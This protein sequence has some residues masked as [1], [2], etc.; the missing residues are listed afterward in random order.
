SN[1]E[2]IE[3]HIGAEADASGAADYQIDFGSA[4]IGGTPAT[5]T[6]EVRN[7][8][9]GKMVI[10]PWAVPLPFAIEPADATTIAPGKAA[11]FTFTY[12]PITSGAAQQIVRPLVDGEP[13]PRIRL[14]GVGTA[15][16]LACT[17]IVDFGNVLA[18]TTSTRQVVCTN[19]SAVPVTVQADEVGGD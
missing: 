4:Q 18:G 17:G 15:L 3:L 13:G 8:G 12:R 16:H 7:R 11:T 2:E 14:F 6:L 10:G 19:R 9:D 5:S 1:D